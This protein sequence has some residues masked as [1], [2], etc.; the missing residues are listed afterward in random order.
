MTPYLSV[1][2]FV[3][4]PADEWASRSGRADPARR[5]EMK[6]GH[7]W[8]KLPTNLTQL[9]DED[10]DEDFFVALEALR[11]SIGYLYKFV[12]VCATIRLQ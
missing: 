6:N 5:C 3:L 12:P 10:E 11:R 4:R 7:Q 8:G 2:V 1:F 9:R